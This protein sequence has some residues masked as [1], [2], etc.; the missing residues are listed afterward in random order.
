[1]KPDTTKLSDP[2]K[3][4][5]NVATVKLARIENNSPI[6]TSTYIENI[7]GFDYISYK[8]HHVVFFF[9]EGADLSVLAFRASEVLHLYVT[10]EEE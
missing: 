6:I 3:T 5:I 7:R 10:E 2:V 8:P 1:M 4:K 9:P